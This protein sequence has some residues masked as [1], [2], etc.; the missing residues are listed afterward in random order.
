M[1]GPNPR[2][3]GKNIAFYM[4]EGRPRAQAVAI[5]MNRRRQAGLKTSPNPS[6][7]AREV[8]SP[9]ARFNRLTIAK[10]HMNQNPNPSARN[11][12]NLPFTK[13]NAIQRRMQGQNPDLPS[14]GA[15]GITSLAAKKKLLQAHPALARRLQTGSRPVMTTNRPAGRSRLPDFASMKSGDLEELKRLLSQRTRPKKPKSK[16]HGPHPSARAYERANE[17]A[18]FKRGL[19]NPNT[20]REVLDRMRAKRKKHQARKGLHRLNKRG[21]YP[22]PRGTQS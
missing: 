1:P 4:R 3:T 17:N 8:A 5:A 21:V 20:R 9:H 16:V 7:R 14:G 10:S 12:S 19:T 11:R 15:T 22:G 18:R 13:Q 6:A 2:D